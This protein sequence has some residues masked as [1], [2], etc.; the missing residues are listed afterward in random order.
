MG[1]SGR[2]GKRGR[3]SRAGSRGKR[4]RFHLTRKG[5]TAL[6]WTGGLVL[7]VLAAVL[8]FWAKGHLLP[9]DPAEAKRLAEVAAK[10]AAALKGLMGQGTVLR[11]DPGQEEVIVDR[12]RW[13][14]QT[15]LER[16]QAGGAVARTLG[17][18]RAFFNDGSGARVAW[19]VEGGGY[20]EPPVAKPGP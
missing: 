10:D 7:L 20:R 11:A 4:T 14:A 12:E 2:G 6:A 3:E 1:K 19:Y 8:L 17:L 5:E 16:E 15:P 13:L 9:V 18:R